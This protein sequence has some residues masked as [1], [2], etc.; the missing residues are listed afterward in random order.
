MTPRG[1]SR[2]GPNLQIT[3]I[4]AVNTADW[5]SSESGKGPPGFPTVSTTLRKFLKK[6]FCRGLD[7][8]EGFCIIRNGSDDS[9]IAGPIRGFTVG[10]V[11]Q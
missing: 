1:D 10:S 6:K 11:G 7:V 4:K 5:V 2:C 8:S 3:K 9:Q